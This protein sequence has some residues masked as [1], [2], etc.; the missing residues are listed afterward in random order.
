MGFFPIPVYEGGCTLCDAGKEVGVSGI[1][2]C[3]GD[4][5]CVFLHSDAISNA[6]GATNTFKSL[7]RNSNS[8]TQ[9]LAQAHSFRHFLFNCTPHSIKSAIIITPSPLPSYTPSNPFYD[10]H[11]LQPPHFHTHWNDTIVLTTQ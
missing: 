9:I 1:D 6:T 5:Y 8:G 4:C 7:P 11:C 3:D 10:S 2:L